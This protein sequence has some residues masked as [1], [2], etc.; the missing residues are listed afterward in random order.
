MAHIYAHIVPLKSY[1]QI[2]SFQQKGAI[3]AIFRRITLLCLVG[4][5][6]C[7]LKL[8]MIFSHMIV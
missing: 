7:A 1:T 8:V 2:V 4:F 6:D 5:H 3:G